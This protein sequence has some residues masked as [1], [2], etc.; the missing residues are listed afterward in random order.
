[1]RL[2]KNLSGL[3]LCISIAVVF[4][5]CVTAPEPTINRS[6]GASGSLTPGYDVVYYPQVPADK[7]WDAVL[8]AFQ[9]TIRDTIWIYMGEDHLKYSR[10]SIVKNIA[11]QNNR[12]EI[13]YQR[14]GSYDTRTFTFFYYQM[15]NTSIAAQAGKDGRRGRY[16]III[17]EI[18]TFRAVDL[19]TTQR[20]AD[21]LFFR[22][23]Q[24]KTVVKQYDEK[25][26]L[27]EPVAAQ[28]RALAVKPAV[29]EEQRKLIV[30]ANALTQQK[31]YSKAMA[32]YHKA[33]ALDRT[34]YPE[35]YFNLALLAAQEHLP[36]S[37]I[38][39]M[40]HYLLLRP[41]AK[42]ARSAQDKIYEWEMLFQK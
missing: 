36:V 19:A 20:F 21:A 35:A 30:Q 11:F 34:A 14:V 39:Y 38:F 4:S 18:V 8:T 7:T 32:Q 15:M 23:Q 16:A 24:V 28:Y 3:I 17:P 12:V 6:S 27:F 26:A 31:E 2:L 33:I 5:G 42:D 41:D 37:A 9:Q 13:L 1:M 40:R 22:Q 29:S 10:P 25:L